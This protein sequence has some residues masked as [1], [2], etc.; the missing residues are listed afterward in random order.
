M[1]HIFSQSYIQTNVDARDPRI[2]PLF[3]PAEDFPKNLLVITCAYDDLAPEAEALAEKVKA[4]KGHHVI[5]RRMEKCGH[6]WDKRLKNGTDKEK[7]D[8]AYALAL[9]MLGR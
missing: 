8:E 2:S 9:E 3:A 4:D 6:G 5:L 1:A 7:K